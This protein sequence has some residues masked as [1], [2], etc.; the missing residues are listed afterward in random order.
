MLRVLTLTTLFPDASR[1]NFGIFVERQTLAL[2]ARGDVSV[3]VVAPLGIPPWPLSRLARYRALSLLPMQE[4]WKGL[5]VHRPHFPNLP[6][7]GG[8][9]HALLL[10]RAMTPVLAAIRGEFP[11][12]LIAAEF[13]YPDGPAAVALGRHFGV[14]VSITARGSDIHRWG[15]APGVSGQIV[16]A[17][18]GAAGMLA[19]SEAMRG[20][21]IAMG[22]P[23]ERIEAIATGVDQVRFAPRDRVAGKAALG[24]SGPL[25]VSLGALIPLK[26]HDIV[27]DA[28]ARLPGVNL[29]IAGQGPEQGR[30]EAQVARLGLGER[31]RV[32]GGVPNEEVAALVAAADVMALASE[33]EGLANA[34]LEALASGT[35]VVIPDVGGARQ[36]L[37]TSA[38]AGRIA[39]RTP[40]GFAAAI[41][42]VLAES[43]DPE[44]VRA[45]AAPYTWA[46]NSAQLHRFYSRLA[47]GNGRP[48]ELD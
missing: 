16:A 9:S 10:A 12:D 44:A 47:A 3:R 5:A 24:V 37:R 8:R 20:D 39:P 33:R 36:V 43:P 29:W 13:F 14:P 25:V 11:F 4:R 28:V 19:V 46:A 27:I 35:P 23:G 15:K 2:A 40:E 22:M 26:G 38:V 32:L 34:W 31:V 21:M 45:V 48:A 18:Q 7:L 42:E 1:P 17:G 41:A 6:G 30:L